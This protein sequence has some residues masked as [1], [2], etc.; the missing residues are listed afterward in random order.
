MD[1][2]VPGDGGVLHH[3]SSTHGRTL[4]LDPVFE[5]K[6]RYTYP[7]GTNDHI[8]TYIC[9]RVPP[10]YLPKEGSWGREE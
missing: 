10:P 8:N 2:V 3:M 4:W 5:Y 9:A 6:I 7:S 1:L